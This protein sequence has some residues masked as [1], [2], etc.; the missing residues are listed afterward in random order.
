MSSQP[1]FHVMWDEA[2]DKYFTS[3]NRKYSEQKELRQLKKLEDLQNHLEKE[4]HKFTTYRA[5]FRKITSKLKAVIQPFMAFSSVV[6]SALSQTH[7][8]PASIVLGAVLFLLKAAEDESRQ[9]EWIEQLFEKLRDFTIRLNEYVEH[10][11][12]SLKT[13]VVEILGC[14][15][16]ILASS[17]KAISDGRFKRFTA[18]IFL[19][20][21]KEISSSFE[22]LKELFINENQLLNAIVFATNQRMDKRIDEIQKTTKQLYETTKKFTDHQIKTEQGR[23]HKEILDWM[24]SIFPSKFR[25]QQQD[26]IS[27]REEGTGQW[28]LESDTFTTWLQKTKGSL[29]CPGIPGAGKTIAAATAIDYISNLLSD[30]VGLAY[31]YCNYKSETSASSLLGALLEQLVQQR[32]TVDD[33]ISDLYEKHSTRRTNPSSQEIVTTLQAILKDFSAMYVVLDALDEC[34]NQDGTRNELLTKLCDLQQKVDLRLMITSRSSPDIEKHFLSIPRLE[35]QASSSDVRRFLRSQISRPQVP[36]C[37][38]DDSGL[39][40]LVIDGVAK[41]V[42]GMYVYNAICIYKIR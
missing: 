37:I 35:I 28:F 18:V 16:D 39:Q 42:D 2:V 36:T 8:A 4:G 17:E 15:L 21:D 19:G 41:A 9:Y 6:S 1:T 30:N 26:Y 38:R 10:V 23:R 34:P 12:E 5:Q 31:I 11:T 14:L 40:S 13:K 25:A 32:P 27:E 29:F 3:T 20:T 7:Y 22:K 33:P 24:A